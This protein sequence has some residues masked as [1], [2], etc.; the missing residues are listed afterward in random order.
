MV[1]ER[2]R[3]A[4]PRSGFQFQYLCQK[5]DMMMMNRLETEFQQ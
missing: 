5:L 2:N 4:T 3:S 1:A